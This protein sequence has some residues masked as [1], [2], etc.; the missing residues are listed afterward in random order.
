MCCDPFGIDAR[1]AWYR[2][3]RAYHRLMAVIPPGSMR[4]IT[5]EIDA[6]R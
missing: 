1:V 2:W 5:P 4:W 3:W 6:L